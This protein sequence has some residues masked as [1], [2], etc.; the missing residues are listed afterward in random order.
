MF[1]LFVILYVLGFIAFPIWDAYIGTGVDWDGYRNPPPVFA[2]FGWPIAVP[3]LILIYLSNKLEG[4]KNTRIRV[5]QERV[6]VKLLADKEQE[7]ALAQVEAELKQI[8]RSK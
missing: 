5:E 8:N 3:I 2:A 6:R 7:L 4:V 1:W